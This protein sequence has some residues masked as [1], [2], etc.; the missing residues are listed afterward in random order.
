MA[1]EAIV[2][3]DHAPLRNGGCASGGAEALPSLAPLCTY[4]ALCPFLGAERACEVANWDGRRQ[5]R[6][7][8]QRAPA[9]QQT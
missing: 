6:E 3:G 8:R 4:I 7:Q 1:A 9:R 5:R 2:G